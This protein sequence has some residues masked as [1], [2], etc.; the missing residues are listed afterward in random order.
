[1]FYLI[2]KWFYEPETLL[3]FLRLFKGQPF[4]AMCAAATGFALVYWATPL[5]I[6]AMRRAG[7][8]EQARHYSEL[9]S[10]RK[11]AVPTMGGLVMLPAIIISAFL[12]CDPGSRFVL[13][14]LAAGVCGALLGTGVPK[15]VPPK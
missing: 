10:G 7:V 13:L 12:W 14:A 6:S 2:W 11:S 1:M 3:R 15:N 8:R 9:D 5:F 4:R